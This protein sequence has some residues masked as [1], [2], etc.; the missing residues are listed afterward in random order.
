MSERQPVPDDGVQAPHLRRALQHAER[1]R[2]RL[3]L[4]GR[5]QERSDGESRRLAGGGVA[6]RARLGS[7]GREGDNKYEP[8]YLT[9]SS[10]CGERGK[11]E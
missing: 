7:S 6:S 1:L 3:R 2:Q 10:R 8:A 11:K 9:L 5:G 4:L